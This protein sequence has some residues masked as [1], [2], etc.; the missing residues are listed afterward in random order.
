MH[1]QRRIKFDETRRWRCKNYENRENEHNM[2]GRNAHDGFLR[3]GMD[4]EVP[5]SAM[6]GLCVRRWIAG[7]WKCICEGSYTH[8]ECLDDTQKWYSS[9]DGED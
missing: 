8:M 5:L 2:D 3:Y 7:Q 4:L 9:H 1:L 6:C